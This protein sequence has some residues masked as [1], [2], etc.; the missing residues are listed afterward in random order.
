MLL[1]F[2][3]TRMKETENKINTGFTLDPQLVDHIADRAW[4]SR[5]SRS[6]YVSQLIEKD[7]KLFERR[8]LREKG[9]VHQSNAA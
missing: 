7:I 8:K 1:Q 5:M 9:K 3:R 4:E 2:K 6:Q